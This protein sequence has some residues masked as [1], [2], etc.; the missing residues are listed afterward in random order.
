MVLKPNR[1][2]ENYEVDRDDEDIDY[3]GEDEHH[4]DVDTASSEGGTPQPEDDAPPPANGG[5]N[6]HVDPARAH[7]KRLPPTPY[8]AAE[9]KRQDFK[10]TQNGPDRAVRAVHFL[11]PPCHDSEPFTVPA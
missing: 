7:R 3:D 11:H 1:E 10:T 9:W 6:P 4:N 5:D 8:T 2:V